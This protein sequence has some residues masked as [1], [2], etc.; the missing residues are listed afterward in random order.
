VPIK[1]GDRLGLSFRPE[2]LSI[3]ARDTGRAIQTALHDAAR[4]AGGPR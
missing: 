2:K 1:A 3:F 4:P